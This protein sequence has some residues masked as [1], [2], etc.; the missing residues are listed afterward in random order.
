[1]G[2]TVLAYTAIRR[3]VEMVGRENVYFVVFA[4][5][6]FILDL[7]DLIPPEN[8]FAINAGESS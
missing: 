6:R 2:S 1:M 8:V 5:N 4:E 7:L 3:A